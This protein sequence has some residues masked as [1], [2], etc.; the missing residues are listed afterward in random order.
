[1][2]Q[3]IIHAASLAEALVSLRAR[4]IRDLLVEGGAALASSFIQER[5]V[6]RLIIFRAPIMLG[7]GA[8]NAFAAL[9]P[10]RVESAERWRLI[11][12]RRFDDDEMAVYAP[13]GG[14]AGAI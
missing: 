13:P 10:V 5:L 8:V 11:E 6:D 12:T 2:R 3:Q 4:G 9:P 7:A 14:N 1:M